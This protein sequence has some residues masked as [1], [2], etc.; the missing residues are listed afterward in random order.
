MSW[1]E[2]TLDRTTFHPGETVSG[3]FAPKWGTRARSASA[4]LIHVETTTY[5]RAVRH[6]CPRLELPTSDPQTFA[7]EL[8][9]D[10]PPDLVVASGSVLWYVEVRLDRF[11]PDDVATEP[12]S[13]RAR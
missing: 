7:L 12:I 5:E 4:R 3:R 6:R 8:P 13:V 11:G 9:A 2:L 1:I 10:A